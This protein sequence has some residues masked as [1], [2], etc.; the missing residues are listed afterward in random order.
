MRA[1]QQHQSTRVDDPALLETWREALW[2]LPEREV[3]WDEGMESTRLLEPEEVEQPPRRVQR[4]RVIEAEPVDAPEEAPAT[5][6]EP[7]LDDAYSR[8]F[9]ARPQR[10]RVAPRRRATPASRQD[11]LPGSE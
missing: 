9:A 1:V 8:A 4:R 3:V 5:E 7:Q 11:D 6:P 2:E 10:R